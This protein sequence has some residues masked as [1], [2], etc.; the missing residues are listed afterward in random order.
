MA[1][2]KDL[3]LWTTRMSA[4]DAVAYVIGEATAHIAGRIVG[5]TLT[6]ERK[7]AQRIGA[8]IVIGLVFAFFLVLAILGIG[9]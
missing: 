3:L 2:F 6:L 9:T 4:F 5:R 7:R 1:A 8:S